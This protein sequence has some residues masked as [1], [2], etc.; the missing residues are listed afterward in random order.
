MSLKIGQRLQRT[1]LLVALFLSAAGAAWPQ[2]SPMLRVETGGHTSRVRTVLF[3]PDGSELISVGYDKAVR[4]WNL[5]EGKQED[6]VRYESRPGYE[7][8]LM[9]AALSPDGETLAVAQSGTGRTQCTLL[10]IDRRTRAVKGRPLAGNNQIDYALAF[11]PDGKLL[12]EAG[13]RF[14][15]LWEVAT[16][17]EVWREEFKRGGEYC[18]VT[19][20]AFDGKGR[21]AAGSNNGEVRVW[22]AGRKRRRTHAAGQEVWAVA[23]AP[24]G[25]VAYGGRSNFIGLWDPE[26]GATETLARQSNT[27]TCLAFTPDGKLMLHGGGENFDNHQIQVWSTA[28]G[29]PLYPLGRHD[30]TIMTL[31]VSPD[32]A[33]VAS[34][35]ALG[36]IHVWDLMTR[37]KIATLKGTGSCV[38]TVAWSPDGRSLAWGRTQ[39][40]VLDQ[41]FGLYGPDEVP[42]KPDPKWQRDETRFGSMRLLFNEQQHKL[43]ILNER[44]V[45]IQSIPISK[46]DT[47]RCGAWLSGGSL[48]VGTDLYLEMWDIY[49]AK[50]RRMR[51]FEGHEGPVMALSRSPR[52]NYFASGS[53][54]QT[55][56]VWSLEDKGAPCK[57]ADFSC[58]E[59]LVSLFQG[60]DGEWVAWNDASG[61]Y[62][63]SPAG[64]DIIGWQRGQGADQAALFETAFQMKA[65]YRPDLVFSLLKLG[66]VEAALKAPP[67]PVTQIVAQLPVL[68]VRVDLP[69][70]PSGVGRN[71]VPLFVT[72]EPRV[73]LSAS[74]PNL[75]ASDLIGVE[76]RVL[77]ESRAIRLVDEPG[78]DKV[79]RQVPL[80]PG[81]NRIRVVARSRAGTGQPVL[82]DVD[83][84]PPLPPKGRPNQ[85]VLAV[86]VGKYRDAELQ[87]QPLE[88]PAIDAESVADVFRSPRL[89]LFEDPQ[90]RTLINEQATARGFRAALDQMES[91]IS[92]HNFRD[93]PD[94]VAILFI[95]SHGIADKGKFYFAPYDTAISDLP[96]TSIDSTEIVERLKKLAANNVIL[97]LDHCFSGGV[98]KVVANSVL[99]DI[100]Q[101]NFLSFAACRSSEES[102][103]D[104]KWGHGAF[105]YALLKALR[106]D[107]DAAQAINGEGTVML[108]LVEDYVYDEVTRIVPTVPRFASA[109]LTQRPSLYCPPDMEKVL[110][111]ARVR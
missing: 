37:K 75:S 24:E 38:F 107:L 92:Q 50:P 63:A 12:A 25:R 62:A 94:D 21:L 60:S 68:D 11:S 81:R 85:Y 90:A 2:Q 46:D 97:I 48:V 49:G 6:A 106:G 51:R 18:E 22:D 9:A 103:E 39:E 32:G 72:S 96:G 5:R 82:I 41:C 43:A 61:Y 53:A 78:G 56:R 100:R 17:K 65:N 45:E 52:G 59:P 66:S 86:G 54:D 36:T 23:W 95:A 84:Q 8:L 55:I 83:Y 77:R 71:A 28:T 27:I 89:P 79:E 3:T 19:S 20:V 69:A 14:L 31:A 4:F 67:V 74:V 7:S 44:G 88:Y 105:T 33:R 99:R 1:A 30:F 110:P 29:K 73:T 101:Q 76:A 13:Y 91:Y 108:N 98:S 42:E 70:R 15:R 47:Y 111:L 57:G 80:L 16:G 35:D 34:G 104:D 64:D 40:G 102:L 93:H 109:N 26:A 10:L 87:A 58:V